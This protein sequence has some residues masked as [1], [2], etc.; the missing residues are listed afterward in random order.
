MWNIIGDLLNTTTW[1]RMCACVCGCACANESIIAWLIGW[2]LY[3][4]AMDLQLWLNLYDSATYNIIASKQ[5]PPH[6]HHRTVPAAILYQHHWNWLCITKGL[7]IIWD[8]LRWSSHTFTFR[9]DPIH[10]RSARFPLR[11]SRLNICIFALFFA[12]AYD[13]H[14]WRSD[15]YLHRH[16]AMRHS[17]CMQP[18]GI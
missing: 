9:F 4:I 3:C 7:S 15:A 12:C 17:M 8:C 2:T 18:L 11:P 1:A 13:A 10:K 5:R 14:R 6:H 16:I